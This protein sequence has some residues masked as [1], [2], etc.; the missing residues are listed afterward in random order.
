MHFEKQVVCR[1]N[2]CYAL[3]PL[4]FQGE[5]CFLVGAEKHDPT[6]LF[7]RD[8]RLLST[9]W[10]EP[11][12]VMTLEPLPGGGGAFLA[13]QAFYSPNDGKEARIVIA[14]PRDGGWEVRTLAD[15]PLVHRFGL[16]ARGSVRYL[17]ACTIKNDYQGRDDWRQPG[18]VYA[19]AL[20]EDLSG[21]DA[22]R[23]LRLLPIRTGLWRNHGF[24]KYRDQGCETAL[25]GSQ[26]GLFQFIPPAAPGDFWEVR[27]LLDTPCSDAVMAD[28]DGDGQPE[29]GCFTPFHGD[30]L[31]IYRRQRDGGYALCWQMPCALEM[32]HATWLGSRR[33]RPIW[34]V[35]CRKGLR[36]TLAL[37]WAEGTYR[38]EVVD[39]EAG[40]ANALQLDEDTLVCANHT[41]NEVAIYHISG[42]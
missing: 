12:G 38:T 36:Q 31:Q 7:H 21:F 19:G 8:G 20:P 18:T 1:L 25:I 17:L 4:R 35:G 39:G 27:K 23:Q 16:L 6:Y 40:A 10:T 5:D 30:T 22:R 15:L 14:A 41:A 42:E 26:E 3:A 34:F 37:Y 24:C 32:L 2:K 29:I 11:G 13:T 33:G 9:V 28:F